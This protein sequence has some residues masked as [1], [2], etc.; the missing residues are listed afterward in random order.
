MD[1]CKKCGSSNMEKERL[2][3][4]DIRGNLRQTIL[5]LIKTCLNCGNSEGKAELLN[6]KE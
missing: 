5:C 6:D 4:E 1:K 2:K 3:I